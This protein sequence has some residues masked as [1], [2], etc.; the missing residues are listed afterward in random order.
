MEERLTSGFSID[1]RQ[2][3]KVTIDEDDCHSRQW[4]ALFI[5]EITILKPRVCTFDGEI[6]TSNL[7]VRTWTL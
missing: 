7:M 4:V 5:M 2:S 6:W 3:P 1:D